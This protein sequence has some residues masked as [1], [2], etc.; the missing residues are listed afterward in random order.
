MSLRLDRRSMAPG[1][2]LPDGAEAAIIL[3][4]TL[5]LVLVAIGLVIAG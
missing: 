5:L 4:V 3:A 2:T 1:L